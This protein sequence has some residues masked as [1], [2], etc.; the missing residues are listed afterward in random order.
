MGTCHLLTGFPSQLCLMSDGPGMS[1]CVLP[2]E[3]M[4]KKNLAL[5]G[6]ASQLCQGVPH[7]PLLTRLVSNISSVCRLPKRTFHQVYLRIR[8]VSPSSVKRHKA[9]TLTVSLLGSPSHG[10]R[11]VFL[12]LD[13]QAWTV[14]NVKAFREASASLA[15]AIMLKTWRH[16]D[17]VFTGIRP[18]NPEPLYF[19]FILFF[20]ALRQLLPNPSTSAK[21]F[22]QPCN[23]REPKPGSEIDVGDSCFLQLRSPSFYWYLT[24][25]NPWTT[26][27]WTAWVHL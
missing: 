20:L 2:S 27:V 21:Q 5:A 15:L 11:L 8:P 14:K 23:W 1:S 17:S 26:Q 4:R 18:S 16:Q 13:L 10:W 22:H 3:Q 25:A 9:A 12:E 7:V 6:R 24:I 19:Y